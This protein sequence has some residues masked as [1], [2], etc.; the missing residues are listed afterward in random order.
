MDAFLK[1]FE[2]YKKVTAFVFHGRKVTGSTNVI[3]TVTMS[4][5]SSH[6]IMSINCSFLQVRLFRD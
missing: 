6:L 5:F 3:L 4:H 1:S 2:S